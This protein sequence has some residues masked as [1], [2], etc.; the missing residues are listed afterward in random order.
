[1]VGEVMQTW[2]HPSPPQVME[3][4]IIESKITLVSPYCSI[5]LFMLCRLTVGGGREGVT[6]NWD[7]WNQRVMMQQAS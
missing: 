5:L 3:R 1:M 7:N 2:A 6:N 4:L